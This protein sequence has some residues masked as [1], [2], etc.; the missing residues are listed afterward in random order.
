M[1]LINGI[2]TRQIAYLKGKQNDDGGFGTTVATT[3]A[4][5]VNF[6]VSVL[7]KLRKAQSQS[8]LFFPKNTVLLS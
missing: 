3:L 6:F 5:E 8:A 1:Q 7:K 2:K 4:I